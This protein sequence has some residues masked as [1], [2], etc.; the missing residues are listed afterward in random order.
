MRELILDVMAQN[1][2]PLTIKAIQELLPCKDDG[3][4]YDV[5]SIRARVN[6][7]VARGQLNQAG[8]DGKSNLY[9]HP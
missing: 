2:T 3:S 8:K 1:D 5:G 6:D 4:L 9:V 7:A